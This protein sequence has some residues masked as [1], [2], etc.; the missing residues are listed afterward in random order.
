MAKDAAEKAA[1]LKDRL[2]RLSKGED[3]TGGLGKPV[4]FEKVFMDAG[5][6]RDDIHFW[7]NSL[8]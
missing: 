2:D 8:A 1:A 6:S 4:D 5:F 7:S 3:V